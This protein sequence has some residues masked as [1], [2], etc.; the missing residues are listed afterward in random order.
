MNHINED[1]KVLAQ[2]TDIDGDDDEGLPG[3][4]YPVSEAEIEDLM[5]GSDRPVAERLARLRQI[6][7]DLRA[8]EPADFG[9][10]D[11]KG[12]LGEIEGAI[13]QLETGTAGENGPRGMGELDSTRTRDEDPLAHRETLSPDDDALVSLDEQEAEYGEDDVLDPTE[14]EE[15]DDFRPDRGH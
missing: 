3:F 10:D 12:L 6:R 5:Y 2:D 1:G 9:L 13:I 4:A 7:D 14:W 8:R 15:G 11:P